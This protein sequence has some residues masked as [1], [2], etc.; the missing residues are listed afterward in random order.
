[1]ATLSIKDVPDDLAERLRQRASRNHRSLQGELMAI[2]QQAMQPAQ[3]ALQPAPAP[4]V[5]GV[6]FGGLPILRNGSKSL[7]QLAAE[8]RER[9]PQPV[10]KGPYAVDIIRSERDAR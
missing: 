5:V 10:D 3:S 6:G 9:F 4:E 1:M 2:I 8:H 7:E